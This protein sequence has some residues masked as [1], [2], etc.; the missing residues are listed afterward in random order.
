MNPDKLLIRSIDRVSG[1]SSNFALSL[2]TPLQEG[3]YSLDVLQCPN[4]FYNVASGINNVIP[5]F[6]NSTQKTATIPPGSYTG[7]T[8]AVALAT[9]LTSAS[10]SYNTY[11]VAFNSAQMTFTFTASG[12]GNFQFQYGTVSSALSRGNAQLLGFVKGTDTTAGTSLTSANVC[13]LTYPTFVFLKIDQNNSI[14][15]ASTQSTNTW[16]GGSY[17]IPCDVNGSGIIYYYKEMYF[18]Q[19]C[20]IY[21]N[22]NPTIQLVD[23]FGNVMNLQGAEWDFLLTKV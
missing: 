1:T 22:S 14:A 4:T 17:I 11:A 7:A 19:K 10:S 3:L 5:L 21:P 6:E 20:Y 15:T 23:M 13:D 12:G 2:R 18:D 16:G 8:L 9:A